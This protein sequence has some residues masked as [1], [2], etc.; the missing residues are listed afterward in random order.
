MEKEIQRVKTIERVPFH[1]AKK[2]VQQTFSLHDKASYASVVE[3]PRLPLRTQAVQTT[4]SWVR[5]DEPENVEK[6]PSGVGSKNNATDAGTQASR[7]S[8]SQAQATP[9]P[10]GSPARASLKPSGSQARAHQQQGPQAHAS[11]KPTGP[12]AQARTSSL[13]LEGVSL[14]QVTVRK[15]S[16][17]SRSEREERRRRSSA[18]DRGQKGDKTLVLSNRFDPLEEEVSDS[19]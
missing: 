1:E 18:T 17:R 8:G 16:G 11:L 7:P 5:G 9:R 4:L 15:L 13:S 12:Q 2:K 3:R 10:S 19:E 6:V 14:S